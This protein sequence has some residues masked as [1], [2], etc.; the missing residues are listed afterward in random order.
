MS[1]SGKVPNPCQSYSDPN[2]GPWQVIDFPNKPNSARAW[3]P[4]RVSYSGR[5]PIPARVVSTRIPD[6]G[7]SPV[8]RASLTLPGRGALAECPTLAGFQIPARV[9]S[10][11][12]PD[13]GK[14]PIFRVGLTLPGRGALAE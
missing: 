14:S 11:G 12:I 10:T 4:G 13:N 6:H 5:V 1:Y 2:A 9:I 8:F 7:K 3:S